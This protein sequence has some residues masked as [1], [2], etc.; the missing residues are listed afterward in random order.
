LQKETKKETQ[1]FIHCIDSALEIHVYFYQRNKEKAR[2]ATQL[3]QWKDF[4]NSSPDQQSLFVTY[5]FTDV[6][7]IKNHHMRQHYRDFI[8][9]QWLQEKKENYYHT[10]QQKHDS[11]NGHLRGKKNHSDHLHLSKIPLSVAPRSIYLLQKLILILC[12]HESGPVDCEA[13]FMIP[14]SKDNP[15][16]LLWND[17]LNIIED[18]EYAH[19]KKELDLFISYNMT[20]HIFLQKQYLLHY[21]LEDPQIMDQKKTWPKVLWSRL[22]EQYYSSLEEPPL[23]DNLLH[24]FKTKD[25]LL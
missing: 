19:Y 21:L 13:L 25:F 24:Q 7:S 23:K 9:H 3:Y 11:S 20:K 18:K 15:F 22:L 10:C 16:F 8:K 12:Y 5:L 2:A 6:D 17:L 4:F 14:I 1:T